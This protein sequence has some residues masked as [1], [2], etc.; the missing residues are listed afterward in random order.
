[1]ELILVT[2]PKDCCMSTFAAAQG[3]AARERSERFQINQPRL[4]YS[5]NTLSSAAQ[6]EFDKL[7]SGHGIV[8]NLQTYTTLQQT[9]TSNTPRVHFF[10]VWPI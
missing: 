6:S 8:F 3:I 2:S 5:T 1:M 9:V 7:I 10:V 4:C